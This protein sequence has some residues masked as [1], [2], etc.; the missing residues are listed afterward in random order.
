MADC[1][2]P[3]PPAR[4]G[5]LVVST[6]ISNPA[7]KHEVMHFHPI[8]LLSRGLVPI[9]RQGPNDRHDSNSV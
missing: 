6:L 7:Q 1:K 5:L 2:H 3:C 9:L 8:I 4:Y